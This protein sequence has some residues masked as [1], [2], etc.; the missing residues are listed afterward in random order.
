M[1]NLRKRDQ[2]FQQRKDVSIS[3]DQHFK[4]D[5]IYKEIKRVD[6][7]I[8]KKSIFDRAKCQHVG[9]EF[10]ILRET[11]QHLNESNMWRGFIE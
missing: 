11:D 8:E 7:S 4:S 6:L 3:I 2:D 10:S 1:A 9:R 5:N